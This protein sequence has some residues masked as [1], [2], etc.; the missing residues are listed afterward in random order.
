MDGKYTNGTKVW[1]ITRYDINSGE[2]SDPREG[3]YQERTTGW[4]LDPRCK[5]KTKKD[6]GEDE[7][8]TV[9]ESRVFDTV[10][11]LIVF[12]QNVM[13]K[14]VS[15]C[16]TTYKRYVASRNKAERSKSVLEQ[17]RAMLGTGEQV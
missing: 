16:W 1:F 2:A 15:S 12:L 14:N 8:V 10:S 13:Q 9:P 17:Y 5:V 3:E 7:I 4:T 11:G 6:N